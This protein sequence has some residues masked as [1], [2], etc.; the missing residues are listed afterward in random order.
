M[1]TNN[2]NTK[3][4][5]VKKNKKKID[6]KKIKKNNIK[7]NNTNNN[8]VL[9]IKNRKIKLLKGKGMAESKIV[10]NFILLEKFFLSKDT[11]I[12]NLIKKSNSGFMGSS[13]L[14]GIFEIFQNI[15]LKS[16]WSFCDL[17]SG[18]GRIV[19]LASLFTSSYGI[20]KDK[21][22]YKL[23]LVRKEEL[24]N[25]ILNPIDFYNKN[26]ENINLDNYGLVFMN[27][28]VPFYQDELE[29]MLFR[30]K[31]DYLIDITLF[32]PRFLK[33]NKEFIFNKRRYAMYSTK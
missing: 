23:S 7:K 28:S 26:F 6:V 14:F 29:E 2:M 27:P 21:N 1:N 24:N 25:I 11:E 3:K 8:S 33:K 5:S 22:L 32:E 19:F 16:Y 15:N 30:S 17:G 9:E 18:D 20:E 13:E 10:E 31:T 12:N 4:N